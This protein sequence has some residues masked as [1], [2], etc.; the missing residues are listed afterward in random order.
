MIIRYK[1]EGFIEVDLNDDEIR[2]LNEKRSE[3]MKS[4]I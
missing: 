1:V 3:T 4:I 2:Q